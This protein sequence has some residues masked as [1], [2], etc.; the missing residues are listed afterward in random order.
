MKNNEVPQD[1]INMFNEKP[2][3]LQYAVDEDGNYVQV[4]SVGWEPKNL[5]M[6]QAWEEVE[7]NI[8]MAIEAIKSNEKSPIFYFMYKH[9]MD[10]KI[11]SEYSGFN[12]WKVKRHLKPKGFRKLDDKAFE[13]YRI[14]FK[15]SSIDELKNFKVEEV[16]NSK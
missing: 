13:V 7:E 8:E 14:A 10:V 9:I 11:L 12:V 6:R 4:K 1:D 2:P 5:V 3:E 16:E 15:L